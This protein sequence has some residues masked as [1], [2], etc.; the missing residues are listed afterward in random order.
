MDLVGPNH[1]EILAR[2]KDANIQTLEVTI[3]VSKHE[4]EV[5]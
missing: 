2:G 4:Y 5:I 1:F 3:H